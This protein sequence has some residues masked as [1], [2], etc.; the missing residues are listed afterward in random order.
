[1]NSGKFNRLTPANIVSVVT[2]LETN[3]I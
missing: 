2:K 3:D 1:L